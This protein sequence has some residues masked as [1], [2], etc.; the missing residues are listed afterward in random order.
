MVI[1]IVSKLSIVWYAWCDDGMGILRT[2]TNLMTSRTEHGF[3]IC[4]AWCEHFSGDWKAIGEAI[5]ND[6]KAVE[7]DWKATWKQLERD[8]R[9]IGKKREYYW[10]TIGKFWQ[11]LEQFL[12]NYSNVWQHLVIYGISFTWLEIVWKVILK[13][14]KPIGKQMESDW[15]ITGK[16]LQIFG[17]SWSNIW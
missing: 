9:A 8:R 7:N 11:F 17:N 16:Q 4:G 15:N 1:L 5:G 10:K 13:R 3:M 14:I 6:W 12:A 2:K